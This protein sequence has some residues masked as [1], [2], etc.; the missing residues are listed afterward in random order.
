MTSTIAYTS[1]MSN[2]RKQLWEQITSE[3]LYEPQL[4]RLAEWSWTHRV[5][6]TSEP[7]LP[8][9]PWPGWIGG[10]DDPTL[11]GP[12]CFLKWWEAGQE[13]E[14]HTHP[15]GMLVLVLSG[16]LQIREGRCVEED[17]HTT[18]GPGQWEAEASFEG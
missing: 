14:R 1:E 9:S 10:S 6:L 13:T 11:T 16:R 15:N 17:V 12:R 18:L 3:A 7:E 8:E 2:A 5:S 4:I